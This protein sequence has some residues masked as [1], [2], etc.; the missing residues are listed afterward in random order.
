MGKLNKEKS[1]SIL[2]NRKKR[3]SSYGV[4]DSCLFP[5]DSEIMEI[6]F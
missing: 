6:Y 5:L 2:V 4:E 1:L 3:G